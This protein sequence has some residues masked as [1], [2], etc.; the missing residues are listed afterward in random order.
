MAISQ[1]LSAARAQVD[2]MQSRLM[3]GSTE[4]SNDPSDPDLQILATL[5]E[6]L[7]TSQSA[8]ESAKGVIGSNN[9]KMVS[10]LANLASIRKQVEDATEK[11]RQHLKERIAVTQDQI[12]ALEKEQTQ[13]QKTL[14]T[15]QGQRSRLA[16]LQHDVTS[17]PISSTRAKMRRKRQS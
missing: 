7:S 3:S 12:A 11:M 16:E 4:L 9:P 8:I 17:A 5:K 10:E 6:K 2:T 14:I 1:Q 13:A 15:V